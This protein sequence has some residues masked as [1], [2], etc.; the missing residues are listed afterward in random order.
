MANLERYDRAGIAPYH[1]APQP[2]LADGQDF[3]RVLGAIRR[4][5]R[6]F[7]GI[8][9][10]F[11]LLV[12]VATILAPKSY[13]TTVRLMAGRPGNDFSSN[14]QDTAFPVLN[15]LVLQSGEQ[16]AETLAQLAQQRDIAAKV[17]QQLNLPASPEGLLHQI[18]V[19]PIVNTALLNLSASWKTPQMSAT[20]ANT[21]GQAF[22]EQE[23]DFVRSEATAALGFLQQELPDAQARM[24]DTAAKLAKFQSV[25]GF[26]DASAHTQDVVSRVG[27]LDQR[28]DQL[29]VDQGEAQALLNNVSGQ[30]GSMPATI[31]AS[32]QVTVNPVL[33]DL[34][35]K[36]A[37]VD[38]QLSAAEQ[39]YTPAHPAVIALRQQRAALQAQIAAQP[40][41]VDSGTTTAPNPVYQSLQQQQSTYK[42]RIEGDA[43][44]LKQ[45]RAQ[46]AAAKPELSALPSQEMQFEVV[47]QDAKRAADVYNALSQK[48]SDALI[49]RTT[50]ISDIS[51]VQPATPDAAVKSPSLTI[52]LA[53]A[54]VIGLALALATVYVLDT[55]ERRVRTDTDFPMM[56]G[57][58]LI[59]RIPA[60]DTS[61]QRMLPWVQSMTI[62]A[63]LHL[64]ITLR[65]KSKQ[66]LRTLA[67]MSPSRG[68]GKTTVALNL[69]KA[70]ANLQPRV[71]LIDADLRRP[72]LHE[73]TSTPN[74][75]GLSDVVGQNCSLQSAAR[76]IEPNL[77]LLTSGTHVENPVSLLQSAEFANLIDEAR[78]TYSVVIVDAPPLH[79]FSDGLLICTRVD[80][81]LLVVAANTTD[82]KEARNAAVQ[83]SVLGIDNVLGIVLNKDTARIDDYS[84][85]FSEGF[86]PTLTGG[87]S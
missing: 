76:T 49:A 18:S 60:I 86:R 61:N 65:L 83:L 43:A 15:A 24:R 46:R 4:R 45:L 74:Q 75:L 50:A 72:S 80:G 40:S 53:I 1:G 28:I 66:P 7:V 69:A 70:M 21:F 87:L 13:T 2:K 56:F 25:N 33:E 48:Y 52:N 10:G 8:F 29:T 12:G 16:S 85:Y 42:A 9:G 54:I 6:L 36:L 20:I 22:V 71:L 17:V 57:L 41:D 30:L 23:R 67:V 32:K 79:T 11:V 82:E 63:F 27:N 68:D 81:T 14:Q 19:K 38:T 44:Q 47:Q 51:I 55:M 58:P 64:C 39:E 77:D 5:W 59:A 84:D 31:D 26:I 62:E 34:R 35:T 3:L 37:A 73:R 78:R